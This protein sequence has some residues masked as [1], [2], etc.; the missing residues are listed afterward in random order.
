VAAKTLD[1]DLPGIF[2]LQADGSTLLLRAGSGWAQGAIGRA[3][4]EA[5]GNTHAG[6]VLTAS[7]AV[8]VCDFRNETRFGRSALLQEHGVLSGIGVVIHACG[9][10]E[11]P[12]GM[13]GVHSRVPRQYSDDDINFLQALGNV[14]AT[15]IMRS[16]ADAKV[17]E[18]KQIAQDERIR[19]ALAEDAL[20]ARD[21]FLSVAAHEL[22][23]PVAALHLQLE[24]LHELLRGRDYDSDPRIS[25]KANRARKTV[26]RLT[27][28]IEGVL[29]VSRIALGSL[30]LERERFDL[31][32]VVHD[33]VARHED[34]AQR[35]GCELRIRAPGSASGWW[36]RVRLEQVITNLLSNALKFGAGKPVE[37]SVQQRDRHVTLT[38]EDHGEGIDP[39]DAQR[40]LH[41]FER[42]VSHR[43]YG[44]L[45]LGLYIAGQIVQEHGGQL[46]VCSRPGKGAA[47]TVMLP[48]DG[49][50]AGA[51]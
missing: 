50:Q 9:P 15:A 3:V 6:Y 12:Y 47:F 38:V 37:L 49:E 10:D 48:R 36:D 39:A 34:L 32:E 1:I 41:R 25:E 28:L 33:V 40:I 31:V 19:A 18:A 21:E 26:E 46:D 4:V 8:V 5:D 7:E 42:A 44:G 14:I 16:A 20:R 45:G 23:T 30:E 2:E 11:R 22:R 27:R 35:A 29:D 51:R 17:V 43:H 13:L 24:A